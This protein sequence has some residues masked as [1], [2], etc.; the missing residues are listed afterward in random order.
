MEILVKKCLMPL[1]LKTQNDS[2]AFIHEL[3]KEMHADL[4]Y[5]E[6]LEDELDELES[7]KAEFSNMYDMLLQECVSKD[8][9]CS[10]LLT[11]SD[12][13]EITELRLDLQ[14]KLE[15]HSISLEIALQECQVRLKNDTVCTEKASN[16]FR[17]ERE[18][19]VEIQDLKAQLQD[20]NMAIRVAHKTNVS[21][22]Q[23]RSN[24]LKDK[25]VPYTSHAKLKKTEVEDTVDSSM[26][27]KTKS[28]T[29][30]NDSLN[31][32][33][34]NANAI[35]QLHANTLL[36][37]DAPSIDGQCITAVQFY[38][39]N[40]GYRVRFANYKFAQFLAMEILIKKQS[41]SSLQRRSPSITI[42]SQFGPFCM[43]F[44]G[45]ISEKSTCFVRDLQGNDLITWYRGS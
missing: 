31:S 14:I 6:S 2:L 12:L 45:C 38:V 29:A 15:K 33:T 3:K 10:Y 43:R 30:C 27:N 34:S 44:G 39:T 36:T 24:Q 22:P 37:L 17:K 26:S 16:V 35:V 21:R 28:V 7:D 23:P 25:V 5:V 1:A 19:Y 4:K 8:V 11:S 13:D 40:S 18:Q 20:K 41:R 42:F 32:R 9:M